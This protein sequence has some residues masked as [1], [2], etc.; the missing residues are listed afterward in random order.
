MFSHSRY[1]LP[2]SKKYVIWLFS[3]RF[4]DVMSVIAV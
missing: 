4:I 3:T 2:I 1:A